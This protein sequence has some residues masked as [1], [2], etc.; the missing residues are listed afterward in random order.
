MDMKAQKAETEQVFR[1]IAAME[2]LPARAVI[3]FQFL[4][5]DDRSDWD[6]FTEAAE[7]QGYDVEWYGAEDEDD[8]PTFEVSTPEVELSVETLWAHEER[9]TLLGAVH[10]FVPDGWGFAGA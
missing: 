2:R 3:S 5:E 9:L 4:A 1:E 6:A 7:G 10:G 8:E